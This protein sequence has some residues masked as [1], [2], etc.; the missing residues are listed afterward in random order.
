MLWTDVSSRIYDHP[1]IMIMRRDSPAVPFKK[2]LSREWASNITTLYVDEV[3]SKSKNTQRKCVKLPKRFKLESDAERKR[4]RSGSSGSNFR[5]KVQHRAQTY[6]LVSPAAGQF[7]DVWG[8]LSLEE[9]NGPVGPL[10][11]SHSRI[12]Q[13]AS[14]S[15]TDT[16][17]VILGRTTSWNIFQV[18]PKLLS[19]VRLERGYPD[20]RLAKTRYPVRR[21]IRCVA[22]FRDPV[23]WRHRSK[24]KGTKISLAGV[25]LDDQS[26]RCPFDDPFHAAVPE[27][28]FNASRYLRTTHLQSPAKCSNTPV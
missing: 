8:E 24:Y 28:S 23:F 10:S 1:C 19:D 4:K 21:Y 17:H 22:L 15:V 11:P 5:R 3:S 2:A 6:R 13:H 18:I 25:T 26:V 9:G 12:W 14:R 27:V 16:T 20:P 7:R